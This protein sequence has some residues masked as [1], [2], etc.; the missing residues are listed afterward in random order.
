[1]R[2]K[3][4]NE[5]HRETRQAA[6]SSRTNEKPIDGGGS[7]H[8]YRTQAEAGAAQRAQNAVEMDPKRPMP[9]DINQSP[10]VERLAQEQAEL[11]KQKQQETEKAQT[12]KNVQRQKQ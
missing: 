12:Q 1:M 8:A 2:T 5:A 10:Q 11:L 7:D 4:E 9:T 3:T 6:E